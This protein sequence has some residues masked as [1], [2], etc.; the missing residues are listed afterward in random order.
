MSSQPVRARQV[1]GEALDRPAAE[2]AAFL[3]AACGEDAVLRQLVTELLADHAELEAALPETTLRGECPGGSIGP[4]KL[5]EVIGEGGF[6]TVWMAEQQQPIRRKVALKVVKW[7]MDTRAVVARFEAER[8]ALAL[9]E[10]PHIAKVFDGGA[11]ATGRPYFAMELVRGV[12]ITQYCDEVKLTPQERIALFVPVCEAVQHAHQK[13]V[14]HRDLKPSNVLVTLHDGKPVPKVIDFG[15]AKATAGQLTDKTVFTGFRQMLGT[16]EYMAPEQAEMSGLDV[17]T[18]ADVYSLGALLYELL[19]GTKPFKLEDVLDAGW[20]EL[21]HQIRE[22]DPEKPSTRVS[23]LGDRVTA[24]ATHRRMLPKGLSNAFRGDVDWI[25]LKAMEKE[26]TRRYETAHA[27]AED[28]QRYLRD[29]PVLAGPP[30]GLYRLR[31]YARRHRLGVFAGLAVTLSLVAGA[32]AAGWGYLRAEDQA[33]AALLS[34]GIAEAQAEEAQ[35]AR[36]AEQQQ[37]TLAEQRERDTRRQAEKAMHLAGLLR[38]MLSGSDPHEKKGL[39]YRVRELLADFE[40]EVGVQLQAEPEV[41]AMLRATLGS[42]Y[43]GLGLTEQ[44]APHLQRSLELHETLHGADSPDY[45]VALGDLAHLRHDQGRYPQA[46]GLLE[47][48]SVLAGAAGPSRQLDLAGYLL[49]QADA[50]R[51]LGRGAPAEELARQSLALQVQL[52]G[53]RDPAVAGVRLELARILQFQGQ[54]AAAEAQCREALDLLVE[55]HGENDLDVASARHD[56]ADLLQGQGRLVAA[57]RLHRQALATRQALLPEPHSLIAGSQQRLAVVLAEAGQLAAAEDLQRLALRTAEQTLG[58]DHPVVADHQVGLAEVLQRRGNFDAAESLFRQALV[59]QVHAFGERHHAVAT[60]RSDLGLLL[61]DRGQAA[62]AEEL[63]CQALALRLEL[64]GDEDEAVAASLDNLAIALSAQDRLDEAEER[65]RQALAMQRRLHGELHPTVATSLHNLGNL[66]TRRGRLDDAVAAHEQALELRMQLFGSEHPTVAMSQGALAGAWLEQGKPKAAEAQLQLALMSAVA[67]LG[68]EHPDVASLRFQLANCLMVLARHDDAAAEFER[69]LAVQR[70]VYGD[71][72]PAVAVT[73]SDL[74]NLFV[75]VGRL[76]EAEKVYRDL[77]ATPPEKI[78]QAPVNLLAARNNLASVLWRCGRPAEAEVLFREVLEE[79]RPLVG[80]LHANYATTLD[81]LGVMQQ[82]QEKLS[83][84]ETTLRRALELRLQLDD[85]AMLPSSQ[86]NLAMLLLRQGKAADAEQLL[87]QALAGLEAMLPAHH[88]NVTMCRHNIGLALADQGKASEAEAFYRQVLE[89]DQKALGATNPKNA[90]TLSNLAS[91]LE[92]QERGGEAVISLE[93]AVT[94]LRAA[95]P[96]YRGQLAL[97]TGGLGRLLVR[98][99]DLVGAE[100]LLAE[101][102]D[103]WQETVGEQ[104]RRFR[105]SLRDHADALH[106]LGRLAESRARYA[107]ALELAR[108]QQDIADSELLELELHLVLVDAREFAAAETLVQAQ[109]KRRLE[110]LGKD[111]LGLARTQFCLGRVLLLAD[112]SAVAEPL[113]R[114]AL[115]IREMQQPDAWECGH[116]RALLGGC[117]LALGRTVEAEPLL[118]DGYQGMLKASV[119]LPFR[120]EVIAWLARL[121]EMTA[122]AEEA[123]QWRAQLPP[124]DAADGTPVRTGR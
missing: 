47:R 56:L 29:E 102:V 109:L 62:K 44:A 1:F 42:T 98:R 91:V 69:A 79:L 23:T 90:T 33:A 48:A 22:V 106:R 55:H 7:G 16:P 92:A 27:L 60:T 120:A 72:H 108:A 67:R 63:Q 113:L 68:E 9:M 71:D 51:H 115:R 123:A 76:A 46:I 78:A 83:E 89:L 54:L 45:A 96:E 111:D 13:G 94:V 112:K 124:R 14:V 107:A 64:F 86:N 105:N 11:T 19:T 38:S 10:H 121:C 61:L 15:I 12:P 41:E 74:A 85:R 116:A 93:A 32:A 110:R 104:D 26:R 21:L 37:R 103:S 3:N 59:L 117:L 34:A 25:V 119:P 58:A 66:L 30:G 35:L 31:K 77:L 4:Y 28:L 99:G 122:K 114:E 82:E 8:Q 87:R 24:I 97:E 65:Q 6:G 70:K 50:L 118:R 100:P 52:R 36:A 81:N 75:Q 18:R 17:D 84:A 80:E 43:L 73:R 57:E 2:R 40:R 20:M 101:A 53:E 88:P 39:D 5:L 49:Q 95:G